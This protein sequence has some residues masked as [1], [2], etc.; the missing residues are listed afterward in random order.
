[1]LA[2]MQKVVISEI[3]NSERYGKTRGLYRS[4]HALV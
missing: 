2:C 4:M 1:L 3:L